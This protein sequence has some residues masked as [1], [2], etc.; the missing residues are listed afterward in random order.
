MHIFPALLAL[1]AVVNANPVA[2]PQGVTVDI[3]PAAPA[4]PGCS[5][6]ASG[7]YSIHIYNVSSTT[8]VGKRGVPTMTVAPVSMIGDGQVQGGVS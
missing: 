7:S 6:S 1:A 5:S 8:V 2:R 3:S 4:P